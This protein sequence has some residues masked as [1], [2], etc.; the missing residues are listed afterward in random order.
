MYFTDEDR[1]ALLKIAISLVDFLDGE[2]EREM[3]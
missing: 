1:Q 3:P 2:L